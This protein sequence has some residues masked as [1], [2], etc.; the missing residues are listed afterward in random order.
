M[1]KRGSE[2]FGG[3]EGMNLTNMGGKSRFFNN[4]GKDDQ[5][6]SYTPKIRPSKGPDDDPGLNFYKVEE[7]KQNRFQRS[8]TIAKGDRNFATAATNKQDTTALAS[9]K[10]SIMILK[11]NC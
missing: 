8:N 10:K 1:G 9:F 6:G 5:S 4:A 11:K 7:Q 2:N 3:Q